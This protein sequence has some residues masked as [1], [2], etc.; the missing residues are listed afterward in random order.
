[1]RRTATALLLGLI[2]LAPP[3]ALATQTDPVLEIARAIRSDAAA[4]QLVQIDATFP[5][6]DLVQ[7][8]VPLQILLRD[9][10]GGGTHYV[11]VALGAGI[12]EGNAAALADGLDAGDVAALLAAGTPLAGARVLHMGVGRIELWIPHAFPLADAEV[13]LFIVYEG[14]PI[15]SNPAPIEGDAP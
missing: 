13:Q 15:L 8:L 12:F 7:R 2:A 9:T 11:R 5:A 1:M 10:S 14:D 3:R 6:D 4:G